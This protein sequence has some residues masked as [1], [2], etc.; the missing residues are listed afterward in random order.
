ML[1]AEQSQRAHKKKWEKH[2][3]V[4]LPFLGKYCPF[5]PAV[6]NTSE[7]GLLSVTLAWIWPIHMGYQGPIHIFNGLTNIERNI[8]RLLLAWMQARCWSVSTPS[9]RLCTQRIISWGGA[10]SAPVEAPK[11][12]LNDRLPSSSAW[13]VRAELEGRGKKV[14]AWGSQG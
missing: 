2:V 6:E 11:L 8:P 13:D 5:S 9:C 4:W 12:V 3:H 1:A 7:P 14:T 10:H